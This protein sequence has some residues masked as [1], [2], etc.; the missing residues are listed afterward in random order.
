MRRWGLSAVATDVKVPNLLPRKNVLKCDLSD[1]QIWNVFQMT[2]WG[3]LVCRLGKIHFEFFFFP[4][5]DATHIMHTVCTVRRVYVQCIC[6][7]RA[8]LILLSVRVGCCMYSTNVTE[9]YS[10]RL[11]CLV[12]VQP[13]KGNGKHRYY[14]C[15]PTI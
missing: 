7:K 10:L 11:S 6:L 14:R 4:K 13:K 12:F 2:D 5:S 8:L 1:V 15:L 3:V 9:Y